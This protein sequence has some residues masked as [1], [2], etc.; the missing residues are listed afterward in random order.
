MIIANVVW[1]ALY[2]SQR[3]YTWWA[4]VLG[5]LI[6]TAVLYR[7]TRKPVLKCFVIAFTANATSA[8]IGYFTFIWVGFAWEYLI[9]YTLY[10]IIPIG[11]FNPF[12]WLATTILAALFS[13]T[14]EWSI[15]KYVFKTP[16]T[17][18]FFWI[19]FS[20]NLITAG[21]ALVTLFTNPIEL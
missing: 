11:T 8:A 17:K 9:S 20:A 12:G 18:R 2:L 4:I 6:E 1:P 7:L 3:Y 15:I 21:I 16:T 14:I 10:M 13:C 19:F 5:L